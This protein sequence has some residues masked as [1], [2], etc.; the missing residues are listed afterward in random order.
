MKCICLIYRKY[1]FFVNWKLFQDTESLI[2]AVSSA[3]MYTYMLYLL[4]LTGNCTHEFS[5]SHLSF[6][7]HWRTLL[8]GET[9]V[10][11]HL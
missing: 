9:E 2:N 1:N 6:I 11:L 10:H 4:I 3:N 8:K 7:C 5:Q